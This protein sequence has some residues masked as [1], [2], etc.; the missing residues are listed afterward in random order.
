MKTASGRNGLDGVERVLYKLSQVLEG[1]Q[2]K[3]KVYFVEGEK[4]VETLLKKGKLATC[5][6]G[7][8]IQNWQDSY[9]A[10]LK[11]AD[12]I[13]IPD[14]DKIGQEFATKVA[15]S[16]VG[17]VNTV[18]LLNLK[19][20]WTDLKEKGDITDV[21]E[22]VNNDKE[23]LEKLE[24]LEKETGLYIKKIKP[25]EKKPKILEVEELDLKLKLPKPYEVSKEEG[26]ILIK[27]VRDVPIRIQVSPILIIISKILKS[28]DTDEE[29]VELAYYKR[30]KWNKLIVD[31]NT[32]YNTQNILN[33]ANKG[34]SVSSKNKNELV[35]WFYDL[36][37]ENLDNDIPVEY[38]TNR[39]GWIDKNTFVPYRNNNIHLE[40]EPGIK[41]WLDKIGEK[42]RN[43][44]R[45]GN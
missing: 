25:L 15:D 23:V 26:V 4:D 5:I 36:E 40:L 14:N 30:K 27:W 39:M 12:V 33:L 34:I 18:K 38:T 44:R 24:E 11:N 10:S 13:I 9:T 21:F 32:L 20:K 2:N 7:G 6:A 29:K 45:M 16:L 3:E 42:R 41:T 28:I 31:K 22:M 37:N 19:N 8:A 1:I 35:S 43:Y 17:N